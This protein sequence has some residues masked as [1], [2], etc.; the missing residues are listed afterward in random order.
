MIYPVSYRSQTTYDMAQK[1]LRS[2]YRAVYT[3]AK[4][5][6]REFN[7]DVHDL[8]LILALPCD[9]CGV[10]PSGIDRKDNSK[11]YTRDNITSCCQRCNSIKGNQLDY[12]E[13]KELGYE[14]QQCEAECDLP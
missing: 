11:G 5:F 10:S 6:A 12:L 1:K 3:R 13:M 14:I 4:A 8:D 9:Y 2:R 7:L